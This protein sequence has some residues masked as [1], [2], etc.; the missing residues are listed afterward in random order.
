ML[1]LSFRRLFF[2]FCHYLFG[3]AA[4]A[5]RFRAFQLF[6]SAP[7]CTLF[8]LFFCAAFARRHAFPVNP[9]FDLENLL[10]VGPLSPAT[11]YSA[12]ARPRPCKSS[13]KADLRSDSEMRSPRSSSACSN[14][15]RRKPR[16]RDPVRHRGR[17]RRP[18][19]R[20]HRQAASAS[21]ARRSSLP[22]APT[23]RLSQRSRRA[24]ASREPAF[25]I[26]ARLLESCPS[27]QSGKATRRCSLVSSSR[28]ASPRNSSRSLSLGAR[29]KQPR[30]RPLP[31]FGYC[32]TV[33]QRPLEEFSC[34][35]LVP[36]A[37]LEDFVRDS[38]GLWHNSAEPAA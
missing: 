19:L 38:D 4:L 13:C 12:G 9:N 20:T 22:R 29:R 16:G 37:L 33:G 30:L 31:Q 6:Q 35:K 15:T 8:R 3:H 1:L 14:R 2:R 25:T 27:L 5:F 26:R 17:P 10:V 32:R 36:Q 34:G 18:R 28:T 7:R 23:S 11:R 21:P 24:A